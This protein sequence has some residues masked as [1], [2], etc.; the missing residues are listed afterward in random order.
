MFHK[1]LAFATLAILTL[2]VTTLL[3]ALAVVAPFSIFQSH[4]L[5]LFVV[6]FFCFLFDLDFQHAG[7][8]QTISDVFFS[9]VSFHFSFSFRCKSTGLSVFVVGYIIYAHLVL[10]LHIAVHRQLL[11]C[12]YVCNVY[13]LCIIWM[14]IALCSTV[15]VSWQVLLCRRAWWWWCCCCCFCCIS[16]S[17]LLF[18]WTFVF[19][20]FCIRFVTST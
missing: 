14:Y 10:L 7:I 9:L 6:F 19:V 17:L 4:C 8:Q 13:L 2:T 20:V 1:I 16:L 15:I 3:I 12:L 18:H 5:C 11:C